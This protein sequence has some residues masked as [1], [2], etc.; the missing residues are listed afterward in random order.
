M[1]IFLDWFE[2]EAGIE[3]SIKTAIALFGFVIT[4]T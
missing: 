3:P 4:L 1:A 2:E